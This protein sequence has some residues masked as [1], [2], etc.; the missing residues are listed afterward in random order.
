MSHLSFE[1]QSKV[2]Y[3]L[4]CSEKHGSTAK[5]LMREG[6]NRAEASGSAAAEGV[7]EK[8]RGVVEELSGFED[9]TDTTESDDV[10]ALNNEARE[11][12]KLIY[13]SKAEIG[14]ADLD[15]LKEIK[16]KIDSLLEDV[17][18]ARERHECPTCKIKVESEKVE[19]QPKQELS[20]AEKRRQF[21]EEVRKEYS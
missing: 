7:L 17:Y 16:N 1:G 2:S 4:E 11:I 20:A 15:T 9:D 12:R 5:V 8:I 3:C 13:A 21:I 18:K 14:G 10:M 6:I 19:E